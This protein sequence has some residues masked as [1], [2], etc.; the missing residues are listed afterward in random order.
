MPLHDEDGTALWPELM[1][2]LDE[3]AKHGTLIV[4]RDRRDRRRKIHLP[5]KQGYFR[6]RVAEIRKAAGLDFEVK[7]MGL[8]HG[9]NTESGN[10][11]LTDAQIRALSG[12]R[13]SA[14]TARYTKETMRQRRAGARKRLEE[15]TKGGNLSK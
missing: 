7:F 1:E 13:T 9:G 5:W 2:R 6:H 4:I 12:H 8:R 11:D 3:V 14:M 10:A 15:R